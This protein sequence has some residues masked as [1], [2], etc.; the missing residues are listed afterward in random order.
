MCHGDHHGLHQCLD[1]LVQPANVAVLLSGPGVNLRD[2]IPAFVSLQGVQDQVDVLVDSH[3][4]PRLEFLWLHQPSHWQEVGQS[5]SSLELSLTLA[6]AIMAGFL[7]HKDTSKL[8]WLELG[9]SA[10]ISLGPEFG[11]QTTIRLFFPLE[12]R[13]SD[14]AWHQAME[15]TPL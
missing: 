2:L 14:S 15:R 8:H 12:R 11:F 3:Q 13:R 9:S 4:I 1:L 10:T 7:G 6:L 5:C